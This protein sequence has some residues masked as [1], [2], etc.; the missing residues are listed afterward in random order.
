MQLVRKGEHMKRSLSFAAVAIVLLLIAGASYWAVRETSQPASSSKSVAEA[1]APPVQSPPPVE[2]PPSVGQET[3]QPT[4]S[5]KS[6]AEAPAPPV[7]SP[8]A[9]AASS[10]SAT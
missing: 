4:T 5:S 7:Q 3:S 10:P 8:P 9:P 6:V 2:S 1:P